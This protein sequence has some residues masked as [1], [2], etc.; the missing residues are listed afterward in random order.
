M[1]G[2]RL[3]G[4]LAAPRRSFSAAWLDDGR[5]LV[6]GGTD[7]AGADVLATEVYDP[8]TE[9]WDAAG[10]LHGSHVLPQLVASPGGAALVGGDPAGA[11]ARLE[12]WDGQTEVWAAK[13][14][15]PY[16][17]AADGARL[18]TDRVD[19]LCGARS[20]LD[21]LG[22]NRFVAVKLADGKVHPLPTPAYDRSHAYFCA[23]ADG[24]LLV[25]SG[26][27]SGIGSS[28]SPVEYLVRATEVFDGS[29]QSWVPTGRLA[30]SH[31]SLDR[32]SQC[33]VALPNGDALIV[34]GSDQV[35]TY[36]DV[37]ERWSAATGRWTR[38]APLPDRR[39]L[40]TT[41]LLDENTVL[42]VGGE[43]PGGVKA[44]AYT[45][46]LTADSWSPADALTKPRLGH[47]AVMIS[48]GRLLIIDGASDGSCEILD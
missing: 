5:V 40:H 3:T 47:A 43:G 14:V 8:V 38:M 31:L 30:V 16:L 4:S 45:Y 22:T 26:I 28:G 6:A 35:D 11:D 19:V 15:P 29:T 21:P 42:V 32:A 33:L 12:I 37:V 20:P 18:S 34:A 36:T 10:S 41:T 39:D 9:T 25:A 13:V 44:D 1:A 2:F 27:G 48:H 17:A 24:R 23:L 7:D 46:D